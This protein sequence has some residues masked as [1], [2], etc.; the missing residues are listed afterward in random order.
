MVCLYSAIKMMHG[1]INKSIVTGSG[2]VTLFRWLFRPKVTRGLS[3]SR[4]LWSEQS[5]KE[6]DDTRYCNNTFSSWRWA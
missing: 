2:I 1:P 5:P 6:S 3:S 4:N